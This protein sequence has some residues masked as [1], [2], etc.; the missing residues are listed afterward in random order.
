MFCC[1]GYFQ[2]TLAEVFHRTSFLIKNRRNFFPFCCS[3]GEASRGCSSTTCENF[4]HVFP[5][6]CSRSRSSSIFITARQRKFGTN[7]MVA[8]NRGNLVFAQILR[9]G[10]PRVLYKSEV[11]N[12]FQRCQPDPSTGFRHI[13]ASDELAF[14]F[15]G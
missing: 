9:L 5:E 7:R 11:S 14:G 3:R 15:I 1:S 12:K 10:N 8:S 13:S 6:V 4:P 2:T